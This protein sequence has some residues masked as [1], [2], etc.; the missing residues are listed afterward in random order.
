M[1]Q[2]HQPLD[3]YNK[4]SCGWT[5]DGLTRVHAYP[6][7]FAEHVASQFPKV[8]SHFELQALDPDGRDCEVCG[9][10]MHEHEW[11]VLNPK[12]FAVF[13][14][15]LR[16]VEAGVRK[17]KEYYGYSDDADW[18]SQWMHHVGNATDER[19]NKTVDQMTAKFETAPKL[20]EV[21]VV[22]DREYIFVGNEKTH[23]HLGGLV[24]MEKPE[25]A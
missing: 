19:V 8:I 5:Q 11:A 18:E 17:L 16:F 23:L 3:E 24:T 2:Q 1:F 9:E 25:D 12:G 6:K 14:S 10:H 20:L 21:K 13:C 4:C 7:Y 22:T 15:N